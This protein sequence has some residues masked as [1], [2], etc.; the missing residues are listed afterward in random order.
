PAA[1]GV[2]GAP[3]A[4]P[5]A[6][7]DRGVDAAVR[8]LDLFRPPKARPV[9][10]FTLPTHDGGTFRL[11][12]HR[13]RVVFINFWA[14]WCAPCREEMPAM[15]RLW[16]RH[17]HRA[18][19]M[20]GVSLDSDPQ[21]VGPFVREHGLTFPIALDTRLATAHTYGVRALPTTILV[22]RDGTVV[23]LALGP[24]AWD[25]DAAHSLVEALA[26]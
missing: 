26:R 8:A 4:I 12:D 3:S 5:V 7:A 25:N 15:E 11:A 24:R 19:T 23:A 9:E 1:P 21:A 2:R 6:R 16:R 18:F 20:V 10:D 22:A 14:T 13:G 17:R